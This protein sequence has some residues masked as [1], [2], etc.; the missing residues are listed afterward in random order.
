[1]RPCN[2]N[3]LGELEA[4]GQPEETERKLSFER[5]RYDHVFIYTLR[6]EFYEAN[7]D[8]ENVEYYTG[9]TIE[10]ARVDSNPIHHSRT[11]TTLVVVSIG[12]FNHGCLYYSDYR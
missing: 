11:W 6:W 12:S 7:D 9:L 3:V 8:G 5:W 4:G 1:M 2:K 10:T